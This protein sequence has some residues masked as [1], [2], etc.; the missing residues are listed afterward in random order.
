MTA[1]CFATAVCVLFYRCAA[2]WLVV[3][4]VLCCDEQTPICLQSRSFCVCYSAQFAV[5]FAV[6]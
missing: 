4:A 2:Q 6:L 1:A 5:L 3:H